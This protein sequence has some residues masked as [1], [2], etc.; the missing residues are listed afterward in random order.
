MIHEPVRSLP[1]VSQRLH[2]DLPLI[3]GI[4]AAAA[5]GF[6]VLYSAGGQ[7]LGL[8]L[9]QA[10]RLGM[11]LAL[12]A[13]VA[14]IGPR[15]IA[16]WAP[17][18]YVG[19]VLLLVAV[20][21]AGD[22]GGGAQRWLDL[23]LVRFQPSEM[24]K[25]TVPAMVAA[26]LADNP[27]PP[28][29]PRLLAAAVMILVPTVLIA[30]QPDLGTALLVAA[31][32]GFV[33]FVAGM[34][35]RLI[36]MVGGMVAAFVPLLW[37]FLMH[38]YQRQRVLTFVN[39]ESDPLGSGYHIIQSKIAVGSGGLYG[40]GWLNGTQSQ[41]DF[42]PERSTDFIF[43][44]FSEEFGLLGVVGL[45][46]IYLFVVARGL[47]LVSG[48]QDTFGRLLGASLILTFFVYVFV[49]IGMVTGL[50]PV[51]GVPL[52]LVSYG[53]TSLVTLMVAFGILMSAST[54]RRLLSD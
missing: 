47:Y 45:L 48:A 2:L 6:M 27:L 24:V 22:V 14:Q 9:R 26:Y 17:W 18:L 25:I 51:V 43:A 38:D 20:L 44:V 16:Y 31:S 49:N 41:L 42:I 21:V 7:D 13:L 34:S 33:L 12:M 36:G 15:H 4:V 53:G 29:L 19:S 54:H 28:R 23:G 32:G 37:F 5:V 40:K 35:W 52:P 3:L 1:P 10:A 50:L 46:G 8:V 39:P 11:A 30:S